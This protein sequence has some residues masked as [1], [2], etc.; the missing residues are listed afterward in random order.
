MRQ[1]ELFVCHYW[2]AATLMFFKIRIN[3]LNDLYRD[4]GN[5]VDAII[6]KIA[7]RTTNFNK[8]RY[9][10]SLKRIKLV[11]YSN[12]FKSSTFTEKRAL[13]KIINVIK[14]R[15]SRL[16]LWNTAKLV[17]GFLFATKRNVTTNLPL[18]A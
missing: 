2:I 12:H 11:I 7:I 3:S 5:R 10:T 17:S 13:V 14:P 8:N 15:E 18:K 1:I 6:K 9:M 16:K 4:D